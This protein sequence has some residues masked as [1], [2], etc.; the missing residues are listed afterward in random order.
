[1]NGMKAYFFSR[2]HSRNYLC[3][4]LPLFI[5]IFLSALLISVTAFLYLAQYKLYLE[6]A[7]SSFGSQYFVINDALTDEQ[8]ETAE[9]FG[10]V[11]K[12][13]KVGEYTY[14]VTDNAR[15]A[16]STAEE[17][18][19]LLG[20]ERNGYGTYNIS[21]NR[22][23][24]G[25]Y[26][27]RDPYGGGMTALE[28]FIGLAASCVILIMILFAVIIKGTYAAFS[29]KRSA[30][31]GL[32]RSIGAE[33]RQIYSIL[34]LEMLFYCVPAILLGTAA[35]YCIQ[36][37]ALRFVFSLSVTLICVL[38]VLL[39]TGAVSFVQGRAVMRMD[40]L[41]SVYGRQSFSEKSKNSG[42]SSVISS[43]HPARS[44]AWHFYRSSRGSYR[45]STFIL[46][47]FF[48]LSTAFTLTMAMI[49]ANSMRAIEDNI[50]NVSVQT[51][52]SLPD[53]KTRAGLCD[54]SD[55]YSA[56]EM[57]IFSCAAEKTVDLSASRNT[58]LWSGETM[59][60]TIVYGL[61]ER[62]YQ[63][64][65]SDAGLPAKTNGA[66]LV[67]NVSGT[68]EK[69]A[70]ELP[71][72]NTEK[73]RVNGRTPYNLENENY[74]ELEIAGKSQ[75]Y[76]KLDTVFFPYDVVLILPLEEYRELDEKIYGDSSMKVSTVL[77]HVPE[78]ELGY[79]KERLYADE[80]L[81]QSE[82][83]LV[84]TRQDEIDSVN[85]GLSST[86][87]FFT[88]MIVFCGALGV[89]G[90]VNSIA[91]NIT[92]RRDDIA[93]LCDI[94]LDKGEERKMFLWE[95]LSFLVI[96]FFVSILLTA[97]VAFVYRLFIFNEVTISM[98]LRYMKPTVCIVSD[99]CIAVAIFAVY[100][101]AGRERIKPRESV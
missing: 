92:A 65:L 98:A 86:E 7:V 74:T 48:T 82:Y 96:P 16:Y 15:N 23:L 94:G 87:T 78:N 17:L 75:V 25:L 99:V 84:H 11:E 56:Y 9:S 42:A 28:Q 43:R 68:G 38:C 44:L 63:S 27:I 55:L 58:W 79:V 21:F 101:S 49:C 100:F 5:S 72:D 73:I 80:G 24:L 97:A 26:G 37:A 91:S 50:Y 77:L 32:L 60:H 3:Q 30:E 6:Y 20:L 61:D 69:T 19:S 81:N 2:F 45:M 18:A 40:I 85:A 1:M 89:C 29:R 59:L 4:A 90:T 53:E 57:S 76:P 33:P 51:G 34:F 93:L 67:T 10:H 83:L 46:A 66:I 36:A 47:L 52:Q 12:L 54:E 95:A 8:T 41:D 39:L 62:S 14:V 64:Y 22:Q 70:I 71:L 13:W 88:I 31:W 35:A